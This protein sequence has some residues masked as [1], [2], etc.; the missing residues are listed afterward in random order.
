MQLVK[1]DIKSSEIP[2]VQI[3]QDILCSHVSID[4]IELINEFIMHTDTC[5]IFNICIKYKGELWN[6]DDWN[7]MKDFENVHCNTKDI[8]DIPN[9][10]ELNIIK[11]IIDLWENYEFDT[12]TEFICKCVNNTWTNY[13]IKRGDLICSIEDSMYIFNG[14]T[15]IDINAEYDNKIPMEFNCLKDF[16]PGYWKNHWCNIYSDDLSV[17]VNLNPYLNEILQNYAV[18]EFKRKM[19]IISEF[20]ADGKILLC[21]IKH[22]CKKETTAH[23][24]YMLTTV[25]KNNMEYDFMSFDNEIDNFL[26]SYSSILSDYRLFIY[27]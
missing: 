18:E 5:S 15:L 21:V 9:C 16:Y 27:I 22:T 13:K 26:D 6:I 17:K 2:Y 1:C 20:D 11:T 3:M 24:K 10:S 4:L 12:V 8:V 19:L 23:I 14:N 7:D 25:I